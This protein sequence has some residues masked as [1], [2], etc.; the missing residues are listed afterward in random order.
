MI[1]TLSSNTI[2][3]P[4]RLQEVVDFILTKD[5]FTYDIESKGPNRGFAPK[6][7]VCWISLATYGFACAIPFG[8]PI[9]NNVIGTG[10]DPRTDKNGKIKRFKVPIWDEAPEHMN[11]A[12]VM[13]I[14]KPLF[15]SDLE[16]SAHGGSYDFVAMYKYYGEVI[17]GPY[18]DTIVAEWVVDENHMQ[19][20]LKPMV[21]RVYNFKYDFENVGKQVE[22]HPFNKVSYYAYCDAKWTWLRRCRLKELI[23]QENV[24]DIFDLEMGVFRVL[25]DMKLAGARVDEKRLLEMKEE[26]SVKLEQVETQMYRTAGREFNIN[27][28]PQ[29]QELLFGP[30]SEGGQGLK[31]WKL[32]DGG[33]KKKKAKQP[34]TIKDYSTDAE[35]LES[36][37]QNA[38]CKVLLEYQEVNKVLGTYVIGYLGDGAKKPR[39]IHDE[40]I[41]ADF[42]QYGAETGRFSCREP[43]LQNI[44]RPSTELGKLVRGAYLAEEGGKLIV[45]DYGQVELVI[46]AHF[47]GHG[48]L[49]DGFHAGIDPHQMTAAGALGKAPELVTPD[50]RQ[51]FGKTLNFAMGYGVGDMKVASMLGVTPDE[52]KD[53]LKTL[54]NSMPEIEAYKKA[55]WADARQQSPVPFTTTLMGRKRRVKDLLLPDTQANWGRRGGAERQVFNAKIQGSNADII[56]YAMILTHQTLPEGAKLILTVHDELVVSAPDSI[57]EEAKLALEQAM[58]GPEIQ[59]LLRVPVQTTAKIV[60]RWSEAK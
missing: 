12:Q 56:K 58:V 39:R 54:R 53:I 6:A 20:G 27:S 23:K 45:A 29:K 36:F 25:I 14:L 42:V 22:I 31:P 59:G 47:L 40:H 5:A 41:H 51:L 26:L 3:T 18:F 2:T 19:Y 11:A 46:L 8:H 34:L 50:E 60:T 35:V 17:P 44:P 4:E 28:A 10:I 33:K 49:Y 13:K 37:P 15:F 48:M 21:E 57:V 7:D 30:K 1:D 16:K 38:V 43:N 9:G 52:A 55:V 24:Q 32:T